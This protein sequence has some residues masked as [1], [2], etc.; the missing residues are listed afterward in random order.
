MSETRFKMVGR[1]N[2]ADAHRGS[3]SNDSS[4]I[5][6]S[7]RV[8]LLEAQTQTAIQRLQTAIDALQSLLDAARLAQ[9]PAQAER[10]QA[11]LDEAERS[12]LVAVC[13]AHA[14]AA[15]TAQMAEH[16]RRRD[17]AAARTARV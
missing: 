16:G 10:W 15:L 12:H 4:R 17:A 3:D 11:V 13:H 2:L 5:R 7:E 14:L 1:L 6:V 8:S 9:A